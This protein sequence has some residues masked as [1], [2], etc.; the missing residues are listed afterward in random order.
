MKMDARQLMTPAQPCLNEAESVVLAA[1]RMRALG[2]TSVPVSGAGD[3]FIGMLSERDI[4]ERCV[5]DA[6]DPRA[7][8]VGALV[9]YCE[10]TVSADHPADSTVLSMVLRQP[11][12]QLPVVDNGVLVGVITLAGIASLLID[13]RDPDGAAGRLFWPM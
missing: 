4:V 12:G 5:A 9:Q 3:D 8:S 11:M 1:R 7:M 6:Q 10:Q 2:V 13:D